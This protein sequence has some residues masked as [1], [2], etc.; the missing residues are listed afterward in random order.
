M[1]KERLKIQ[2]E[3]RAK[4]VND[5]KILVPNIEIIEGLC[6]SFN[7]YTVSVVKSKITI[8]K[9]NRAVYLNDIPENVIKDKYFSA[10]DAETAIELVMPHAKR[11]FSE[12]L[13]AVMNL[14]RRMNFC[15]GFS[16][17][18]DT[19]GIY[20]DHQYISFDLDGF[21]FSFEM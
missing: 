19:H 15:V 18:G 5:L 10:H 21:S 2:D 13:D 4:V 3:M 7:Y 16:Y 9:Y 20:D 17:E 1:G 6:P 8:S 12:C 14:K 11:K